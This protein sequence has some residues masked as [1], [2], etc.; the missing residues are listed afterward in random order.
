MFFGYGKIRTQRRP[1]IDRRLTVFARRHYGI[2]SACADLRFSPAAELIRR[3]A[4][5]S[6]KPDRILERDGERHFDGVT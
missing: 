1:A 4:E 6:N 5:N 2:K 3:S